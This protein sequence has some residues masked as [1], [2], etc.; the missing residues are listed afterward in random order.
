MKAEVKAQWIAALLSGDYKQGKHVLRTDTDEY[1]CLGVLC[2]VSRELEGVQHGQW[3]RPHPGARYTFAMGES[4]ASSQSWSS[5]P[6]QLAKELGLEVTV[7]KDSGVHVSVQT[8][9]QELNDAEGWDFEQIAE[10]IDVEIPVTD[11]ELI[12]ALD[13]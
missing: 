10:F 13:K 1:C 6:V 2:E 5:V 3:I 12:V 8:R 9:L 7:V 11:E 4:P